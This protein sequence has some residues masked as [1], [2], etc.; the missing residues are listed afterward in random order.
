MK[1]FCI[2]LYG[3]ILLSFSGCPQLGDPAGD[4]TVTIQNNTDITIKYYIDSSELVSKYNPF[5][6]THI[7][8]IQPHD[9][10]HIF[11]WWHS[12]F[13]KFKYVRIFLFDEKVVQ[14]VPWDTIRVNNMYLKRI[15]VTK[16]MLDSLDWILTYP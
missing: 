1:I 4:S 2:I 10:I 11:E 12:L 15:D 16:Q 5:A 14:T 6:G 8:V 3:L 9:N 7:P 13:K